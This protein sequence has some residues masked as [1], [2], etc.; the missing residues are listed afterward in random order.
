MNVLANDVLFVFG[1]AGAAAGGF[2]GV[3]GSVLVLNVKS[4]TDAGV[5]PYASI[6]AGGAVTIS[7]SM[8]EHS[9]PIG[10]AAGFGAVGVG[11]QVAVVNDTG[12]QN[13]HIDDNA[14]VTKAGGGLSVT[15]N[16]S[17]DV[18]AY[19]IGAAFGA[20]AIGAAVAVVNVD[21]DASATI[22]NVAVGG[23]SALGGL[24]VGAVDHITSDTLVIAVAGGIG[25]GLGAAVAVINLDGTLKAT[26][27]AH[28]S[29]AGAVSITA[30]GTHTAKVTSVNVATGA[31]AVGITVDVIKNSRNTEAGTSGSGI[32]FTTPASVTVAATASNLVEA[33]APGGAAGGVAISII[34]ADAQ[35]SGHTRTD[36]EGGFTN[37]NGITVSAIA[38]NTATAITTIFGVAVIGLSGGVA[39]ATIQSGAD[40]TTT[41]G[42]GATLDGGSGAVVVEAKTRNAGNKANAT[43]QGATA[44]LLFAGTLFVGVATIDASVEAHMNGKVAGGT[45]LDVNANGV[46]DAEA[47]TIAGAVSLGGALAG[48]VSYA[49]ISSDAHVVA[50]ADLNAQISI[51][52][53]ST[54]E[55][56][57][58]NTANSTSEV[59]SFGLI[60]LGVSV[61]TST[62]GASTT[63]GY[64]G[65]V[66]GGSGFTV[67][68]TGADTATVDSKPIAIGLIA[69]NGAA[70]DAEITNTAQVDAGIGQHAVLTL[71][72]A[73]AKVQTTVNNSATATLNSE[74][75]G[76]LAVSIMFAE[77][78]D[79]GGSHASFDGELVSASQLT[80]STDV[81]RAV[82]SHMFVLAIALAASAASADA[83]A[84]IGDDAASN[85][86]A[87]LGGDTNIH[88]NGT[89]ITVKASRSASAFSEANGGA[90]G[91]LGSGALM[92]ATTKVQ[93]SVQA[94]AD[95]NATIGTLAG[96]PSNAQFTALDNS[97]AVANATVGS[98]ALGFT[99]GGSITDA[100]VTPTVNA[101]VGNGKVNVAG[102]LF[103]Q[104]NS[105]DAEADATAKSYG[106]ALG[107]HIGAPFSTAKSQAAVHAYI[108]G[109]ATIVAGGKVTVD[110]ESNANGN[111]IPLTDFITGFT[112]DDGT[113]TSATDNSV[114]FTSHSLITG[115]QVLY[116]QNGGGSI[117]L[118]DNHV[119]GVIVVDKNTLRFGAT[120]NS[121]AVDADSVAGSLQG[122]DA[123]RAMVRFG[124]AHNFE[125][126]DAVI[127]R[128]TGTSISSDFS[129]GTVLYVRVIDAYTIELYLDHGDA[130]SAAFTF[131]SGAVSGG[132][133]SNSTLVDGEHVT[134]KAPD[135]LIFDASA[136]DVN[137]DG[138]GGVSGDNSSAFDI[139]LGHNVPLSSSTEHGHGLAEGQAV[140]YQTSGDLASGDWATGTTYAVGTLVIDTFNGLR[141]KAKSTLTNDTVAPH[142]DSA[143]WERSEAVIGGLANGGLYYVHVVDA[144]TI[145]LSTTYCGAVTKSFDS[146]NCSN[147]SR[148]LVPL[149]RPSDNTA[150]QAI[151]PAPINGLTDGFT[152]VVH[153]VNSGH[154]TLRNVGSSTDIG[155]SSSYDTGSVIAGDDFGSTQQLFKAGSALQTASCGSP[156]A[157]CTDQLYL[158]LTGSLAPGVESLKAT[159]DTSLRAASPP[160]GDGQ[161]SATAV[162]GG[163]AAI[164]VAK[165][166]AKVDISPTVKAYVAAGSATIGGDLWITSSVATNSSAYTEN[167]SGG[168]VSIP[169][170]ESDINGT[171]NNTSFIGADF[172]SGG[173]GG[174]NPVPQVDGTNINLTVAGNIKIEAKTKLT[175]SSDAKSD[176]GGGFDDSN[177]DSH[178]NFTDNTAGVIGKNAVVTGSTLSL[179]AT[180]Y[181]DPGEN[182]HAHARSF[183]LAL[184]GSSSASP[185]V[186][187]NSNDTALLDG[188][189]NSNAVITGLNGVDVRAHHENVAYQADGGHTCICLDFHFGSDGSTNVTLSNTATGHEGVTVFA[190]PRIV[191]CT[192]PRPDTTCT[193]RDPKW[194]TPLDTSHGD[195]Y[196][197]LYI[198]AEQ[199]GGADTT[200]RNIVWKSDVVISAGPSPLLIVGPDGHV[201][202]AVNITV[203]GISNPAPGDDLNLATTPVVEVND[204]VNQDT[205]DVWMQSA[206]G[207]I[208]GGVHETTPSDHYWGTF[209]FRDNW[210]FVTIL[211][212]SA[213]ELVIDNI[214]VINRIR[215]PIVNENAPGGSGAD[216]KFAI[217]RQVDP[218][219]VTITN[220]FQPASGSGPILLINGTILNPIGE[221]D[222]TS[223]FGPIAASTIRGG[224]SSTFSGP[225]SSLV[226]SNILKLYAGTSIGAS[227][228]CVYGET[229]CAS[230]KTLCLD[231]ANP[232]LNVDLVAWA[233]HPVFLTTFSGTSQFIDLLTRLRDETLTDPNVS[234]VV[235]TVTI[236][237]MV[238]LDSIFVLLRPTV[239]QSD[240]PLVPGIEVDNA[241][242]PGPHSLPSPPGVFYVTFYYPDGTFCYYP[243][244]QCP[245]PHRELGAFA[246]DVGAHEVESTYNFLLLDAG[247]NGPLGDVTV[248]AFD[249]SPGAT[250]INIIGYVDIHK[251]GDID[252][253][254]NG[255]I[256]YTEKPRP[257]GPNRGDLRVGEIQSTNNDVTLYAPGAVLDADNDSAADVIA[258]NITI[259]AGNNMHGD[260]PTGISG[261][262]GVG[263]P[264]NFLEV[265]VDADGLDAMGHI[266]VLTIND[267]AS[268]RQAWNINA[269]PPA[270]PGAPNGTF[271]V[272]VTQT[273]GDMQVN[274]IL[275][276]GDASLVALN[277]SLRDARF[278]G[279][280]DNNQFSLANVEAN[281]IDLAA[282][283]S[284]S[285]PT[286][287]CGD[288]GARGPP[289]DGPGNDFKIDSGHGDTQNPTAVIVGR[290]G[291]EAQWNISLT[292]TIGALNVLVAQ[293]LNSNLRLTV[294]EHS[295]Q[296]DDLNLILPYASD[297]VA[298]TQNRNAILIDYSGVANVKREISASSATVVTNSAS[299][300]AQNGWILLRAGDDVTLGGLQ[301]APDFIGTVSFQNNGGGGT[302]D[303]ISSNSFNWPAVGWSVG[304]T[305]TI[306]GAGANNGSYHIVEVVNQT[307]LRLAEK[308]VLTTAPSV[309]NVTVSSMVYPDATLT[310]GALNALTDAQRI[311]QNTKVVAGQ[312]V[313]I[314]GDYDA[315][316]SGATNVDA[317]FGTVMHLHG[318]ITPGKL[319]TTC[320]AEIGPARD[321]NVTRIFGN[322]DT[323]T[324]NFDQTFLGGRTRVFGSDAATASGSTAPSCVLLDPKCDSEDFFNVNQLQTMFDPAA[325]SD[326]TKAIVNGDV[327]AGH[328]LTLDGQAGTDT[329]V[330][331]TTGSQPCLGANQIAGSTC[332]NYIV[333]VLDTGRSERRRR[334]ADRE[335]HRQHD[336]QRLQGRRHHAVPDRRHLP[337]ARVELHR[338][339][340]DLEHAERIRGR[341]GLRRPAPRQLRHGNDRLHRRPQDLLHPRL[342]L[343]G[344]D[345]GRRQ[346]VDA[347]TRHRR[348]QHRHLRRR[349]AHPSRRR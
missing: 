303:T 108:G 113:G 36:V 314:Y 245:S 265:Q 261:H 271:G 170:V 147:L 106:G 115:D 274:R 235:P 23:T 89:A 337:A 346:R 77:V 30:D 319:S 126:G 64:D 302:G 269:L 154:I 65:S 111:G 225:H 165:P 253:H 60:S 246:T 142:A 82:D 238:A 103:I 216:A 87:S 264:A 138:S 233:A 149:G 272:F 335:R 237:D 38:D 247:A 51:G 58:T 179:N 61:P 230:G 98:G 4:V 13:A 283:C 347:R 76:G 37:A 95:D 322:T 117:G 318:T 40:I 301:M 7:A 78:H 339:D 2:V 325:N 293:A 209:N 12:T 187:I 127:Y 26:S 282:Y 16:S 292:E 194:A 201:V 344:A 43:A 348:V 34:V 71:N 257:G 284:V 81:T 66:T 295:G 198:Q 308:G 129:D 168:L 330:I 91:L 241:T 279:L 189:K 162:G 338:L 124:T 212:Q 75:F 229:T 186:T 59:I 291:V 342:R 112:P 218:S 67:K 5:A 72:S 135:P 252:S 114:V 213:R 228:G 259:T 333:N 39:I 166:T 49:D 68:A 128:T 250:V 327:V 158:K 211:N 324:I 155:I 9:T 349:P 177:A 35:L 336:V 202:T 277:G 178:I 299:I 276:N 185:T 256:I 329:Y 45:S 298:P 44:G 42:S 193:T 343:C 107:L 196:L 79:R 54:I 240:A 73:T 22:G 161:T 109:G 122:I 139:F 93:G 148:S 263:V 163:G 275:T 222:I 174:D 145:Q 146:T 217:V 160:S 118:H 207:N 289:I 297:T 92:Q 121:A 99:A 203:N 226:Q 254:T 96:K 97:T 270:D 1:I 55:A 206:G 70:A 171:D 340:A 141:Y 332:H 86:E 159:D 74:A 287:D 132:Q 18:H 320:A 116:H 167:G 46:N 172:S 192:G 341:P 232:C 31:G 119:Y 267:I 242:G 205:G 243:N 234:H 345:P 62:I 11:A 316:S 219:L 182:N 307:T 10:F 14:Q 214:D 85:E 280:G 255:F 328:T 224:S 244:G 306:T 56:T 286:L 288:V 164:D 231:T 197:A 200:N 153:R 184:F 175:S 285:S 84:T 221:T 210:K 176:S 248:N 323:D 137:S 130:T 152:Y 223:Q 110:A 266:G 313:E 236:N 180:T 125:T 199:T 181:N 204:L 24:T 21:G 249:P 90:G 321:C 183:V 27:G 32:T 239:Y 311:A 53:T 105:N 262:G 334:R 17:R 15:V 20:G 140:I 69:G 29:L 310:P 251:D 123:N 52:G 50:D 296:G 281:N 326:P 133:I 47:H 268:A 131:T 156:P 63:A 19:A 143:N 94:F 309:A 150:T 305:I 3:G 157:P 28:G 83:K 151:R 304:Q 41:V 88:G 190:G 188:D 258:R 144:W 294:R 317:G 273:T 215:R 48:S 8:D 173:I 315:F 100:E 191:L 312:W 169:S 6:S 25:L 57:G 33:D 120:F 104:A 290:V 220:N 195:K 136:V 134:Y 80:V 278:N 101:Y 227:N 208:S 300:N 102:D 260:G 331:N